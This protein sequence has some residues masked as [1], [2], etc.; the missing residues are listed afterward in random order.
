MQSLSLATFFYNFPF[1]YG[2]NALPIFNLPHIIR[3]TGTVSI[4]FVRK[5]S[6]MII[7]PMFKRSLGG[8]EIYFF[9]FTIT[10]FAI[11]YL[12]FVI[13]TFILALTFKGTPS[14]ILTITFT[15]LIMFFFKFHYVKF[16]D[17]AINIRHTTITN[18]DIILSN[19]LCSGLVTGKF[20][21]NNLKNSLPN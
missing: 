12:H 20:L 18:L 4:L 7:V 8:P 9:I 14:L 16:M 21:F 5:T 2:I 3:E 10:L 6:S 11:I 1:L 17:D 13:Y 19:I 15:G